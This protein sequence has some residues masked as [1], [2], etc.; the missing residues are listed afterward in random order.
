MFCC[1]T[2]QVTDGYRFIEIL[3]FTFQFTAMYTD[4]AQAVREW[5]FFSYGCVGS[6][7]ISLADEADISRNINVSRAAVTARNHIIFFS[8]F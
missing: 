4:I 2:L 3:M 8:D 6:G 1:K 5:N 7:I